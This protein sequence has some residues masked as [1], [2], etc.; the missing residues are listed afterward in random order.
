MRKTLSSSAEIGAFALSSKGSHEEAIK[1]LQA[2]ID[3]WNGIYREKPDEK[4]IK[5]IGDLKSAIWW[6]EQDKSMQE[7]RDAR[8]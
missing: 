6:V 7:A 2:D 4:I 5:N 8:N 3:R 1:F